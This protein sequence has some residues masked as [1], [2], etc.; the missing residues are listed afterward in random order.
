MS[1]SFSTTITRADEPGRVL[2]D[3]F[4]RAP[5][6]GMSAAEYEHR[7]GTGVE[8]SALVAAVA[9]SLP[10]LLGN[11]GEAWESVNV[12]VSGHVNPGNLPREEWA[13]DSVTVSLSVASYAGSAPEA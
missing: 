6:D 8:A 7:K 9:L 2:L 12:S 1:F 3:T 10:V 13:N 5:E 4:S 11:L